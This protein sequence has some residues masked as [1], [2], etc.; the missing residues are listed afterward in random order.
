[1]S[2]PLLTA[3]EPVR[4]VLERE[5]SLLEAPRIGSHGELVYSDVIAGGLWECAPDGSP[6]ELLAGRR[7]IGGVAQHADGGW[8]LSGR[9]VLHL[10]ADGTQRELLADLDVPGYNDISS[11]PDGELL[12]GELRYR[13]MA[14]EEPREGRLVALS[15]AGQVRVLSDE[16]RWPNGIG[17][18]PDGERVYVSDYARQRVMAVPARGGRA[19]VFATAPRG[20]TDGLAVDAQGGVWVALGEG[21]GVARFHAGGQL[22]G[23]LAL[24][25]SFVS[26]ISF[27]GID[28][29]DVLIS[30]ADNRLMP[31]RGGMLLRARSAVPG[32]ALAPLT[33]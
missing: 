14:G 22:D 16:V 9:T 30:T 19:D 11:T 23:V 2:E 18:S 21:G 27:G 32:L 10:R 28:M 7:G 8:V 25:A 6:V 17:V 4:A 20:S 24:P 1:V 13:P 33:V 3:V 15:G 12:A 26:S 5:H 29:C 31:E